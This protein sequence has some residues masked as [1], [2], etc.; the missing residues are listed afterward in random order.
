MSARYGLLKS[1]IVLVLF[2]LLFVSSTA[3]AQPLG[4]HAKV[5]LLNP[6]THSNGLFNV[7]L[8]NTS[9]PIAPVGKLHKKSFEIVIGTIGVYDGVT[10]LNLSIPFHV[11]KIG[12]QTFVAKNETSVPLFVSH[13]HVLKNSSFLV[14]VIE[15]KNITS[16][17]LSHNGSFITI[18]PPSG[19]STFKFVVKDVG[20]LNSQPQSAREI[21]FVPVSV[22]NFRITPMSFARVFEI[23]DKHLGR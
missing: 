13:E 14:G 17:V 22:G 11:I 18:F 12:N 5:V 16:F 21:I 20:R 1:A 6:K 9:L 4:N 2:G 10:Y 3:F 23:P 19:N 8:F 7:G 15:D